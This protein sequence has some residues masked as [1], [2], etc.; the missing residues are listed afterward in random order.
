MNNFVGPELASEILKSNV[1]QNAL[2]ELFSVELIIILS[3]I[4]D[5][6]K[7]EILKNYVNKIHKCKNKNNL[8]TQLNMKNGADLW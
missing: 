7:M 3:K 5:F 1:L 6:E 8:M 2:P 4:I